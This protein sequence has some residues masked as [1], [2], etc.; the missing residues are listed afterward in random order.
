MSRDDLAPAP[1]RHARVD[2]DPAAPGSLVH[3]P[4]APD[5]AAGGIRRTP[6]PKAATRT[7][8]TR[9]LRKQVKTNRTTLRAPATVAAREA[10]SLLQ[11]P[12]A[13]V[14][15]EPLISHAPPCSLSAVQ[16]WSISDHLDIPISTP[17]GFH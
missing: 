14:G 12:A 1:D 13:L 2:P 17:S 15:D 5:S 16:D 8:S 11:T 6:P 10:R 3:E 7:R 4:L 9:V